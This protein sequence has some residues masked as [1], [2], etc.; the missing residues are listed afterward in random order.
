MVAAGTADMAG[1]V[2]RKVGARTMR[3]MADDGGL[4]T[5]SDERDPGPTCPWCSAPLPAA[6]AAVCP[7]CGARLVETTDVEIPGVN[8]VDPELVAMASAPRKLKRTFGALL[9][10][11]DDAVPAAGETER[12][13]LARPEVEMAAFARPD[14]DVRREILRLEMEA[15]QAALRGEAAAREAAGAARD[16]LGA[17]AMSSEPAEPA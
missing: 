3:P 16:A 2:W 13:A 5:P 6:D 12:K 15:R 7:A 9:V 10:G 1:Q 4:A 11:N 8:A 17:A 14:D